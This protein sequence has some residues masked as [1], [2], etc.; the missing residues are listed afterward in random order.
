MSYWCFAGANLSQRH[1]SH[2]HMRASSAKL[3]IVEHGP[4]AREYRVNSLPA[5]SLWLWTT[6]LV[7][8]TAFALVREDV[9][10]SRIELYLRNDS[11]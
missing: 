1:R 3:T 4:Y 9:S 6:I 10:Q 5:W 2:G 8:S 7:L 11:A